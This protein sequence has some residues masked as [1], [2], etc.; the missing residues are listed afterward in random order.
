MRARVGAGPEGAADRCAAQGGAFQVPVML[1]K[2]IGMKLGIAT[3]FR[4]LPGLTCR[5]YK[6]CTSVSTGFVENVR[7]AAPAVPRNALYG[8][9]FGGMPARA[10]GRGR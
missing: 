3:F 1:L 2:N 5:I 9:D 8:A 7:A 4:A 6:I 10:L